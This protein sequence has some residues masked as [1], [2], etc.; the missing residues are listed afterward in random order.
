MES[1]VS[2]MHLF[3]AVSPALVGLIILYIQRMWPWILPMLVVIRPVRRRWASRSRFFPEANIATLLVPLVN[4]VFERH[5]PS[6]GT[7]LIVGCDGMYIAGQKKEMLQNA[8]R[9]WVNRGMTVKYLLVDPDDEALSELERLQGNLEGGELEILP[10]RKIPDDAPKET[11]VMVD[12]LRTVHP[13]L[14]EFDSVRQHKAKEKVMWIESKHLPRDMH[15]SGNRWVPP[16][17]MCETVD[18]S[19][20]KW[21]DVFANWNEKI[22]DVCEYA[23]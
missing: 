19:G 12:V 6:N 8:I 13:T 17:A 4:E 18:L 15:S 5:Q 11:Q 10:L 16:E 14:M 3:I 2:L 21:C 22:M 9:T 7:I 20:M 1:N 23:K